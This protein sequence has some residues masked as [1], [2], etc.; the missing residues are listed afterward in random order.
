MNYLFGGS[1]FG[2]GVWMILFWVAIIALIVWLVRSFSG[3]NQHGG[4][5]GCCGGMN[6]KKEGEQKDHSEHH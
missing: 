5:G 3:G 1:M 4:H 2:G 6:D